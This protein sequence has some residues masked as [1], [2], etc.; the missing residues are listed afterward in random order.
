MHACIHTY[1]HI[2]CPAIYVIATAEERLLAGSH[3]QDDHEPERQATGMVSR[4][5]L[6]FSLLGSPSSVLAQVFASSRV[7]A[8]VLFSVS[9]LMCVCVFVCVCV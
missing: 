3:K 7:R 5:Q 8:R 9:A 4:R 1:I 6:V 2:L